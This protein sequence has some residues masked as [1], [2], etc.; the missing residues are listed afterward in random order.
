MSDDVTIRL[1]TPNDTEEFL[2]MAKRLTMD[3]GQNGSPIHSAREDWDPAVETRLRSEGGSRWQWPVGKP[4]WQRSFGLFLKGTLCGDLTLGGGPLETEQHRAMLSIGLLPEA[5]C[6]GHGRRMMDMAIRWAADQPSL[7]WIV[8]GVFAGNHAAHALYKK[9][10]FEE[11]GRIPDRFRIHG[12]SI[13]DVDMLLD[14]NAW[15][16]THFSD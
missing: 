6:Q 10:G 11:H 7:S 4:R 15:R 12:Q 1:L 3:S 8:L 16:Q 2:R 14:L 5:R 9:L 13:D